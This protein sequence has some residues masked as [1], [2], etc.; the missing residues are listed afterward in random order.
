MIAGAP[1]C[2]LK[3]QGCGICN[4]QTQ[5]G[6][7]FSDAVMDSFIKAVVIVCMY[8]DISMII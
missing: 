2:D 3:E 5:R 7:P 8:Y 1:Y 6:F 4:E